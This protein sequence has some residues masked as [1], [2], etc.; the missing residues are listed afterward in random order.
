MAYDAARYG[1][2]VM[3]DAMKAHGLRY[4]SLNPGSSFRGLHDS[5]VNY[6]GNSPEII[7]CPHE[8]VA[9][10]LAHGYA[11]A[12]GEAMGVI[13]HNVVGLL[14][15][16][17]GIYYAYL[18]RTPVVIFGGT[19]PMALERRRPN[20]DWI[21]TANVQGNAVRDYTK[22]DDQPATVRSVPETIARGYRIAMSEPR[23]PV[24]ICLDAGLQE[25][26][27]TEE[28]PPVDP[29]RYQVPS[30][31]GPDPLALDRL[32]RMLVDARRPVIVPGY[33]GRDPAAFDQLVELAEL[34]G[35]GVIDTGIRLNFPN[36]HPLNVTGSDD[37]LSD[38]DLVFFLDVKDF[39]KPTQ[40]LDRLTRTITSRIPADAKIVD[41]GFNDLEISSWSHDF[42]ALHP[43]DLQVTADSAVALPMLLDRCKE[44][45]RAD[46]G[47]RPAR[48]ERKS[49][50]AGRHEA[51]WEGW[52]RQAKADRDLSPVSTSRLAEEVW[53][54]VKEHDWVL[55]AGTASGW[56]PRIWDFDRAYRH[57][58]ASLGTATQISISLGVAL[59]HKGSGKLVVDLQPDGDLMFDPGALWVAAYHKIPMLVVMFNNR[60]YYN[61]WEHQERIAR[62]RGTPVENA[63]LG[64]E[65]DGPAP[66]FANIARSFGWYGEGP[67][68]DPEQVQAAV[69]RAAEIVMSTG[70]PALVDV[71]CQHE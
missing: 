41:L 69:R 57:P 62:H 68:D 67:I 12:T 10:G 39:G 22:W 27:L 1:S 43:T 70:Q 40:V 11:K 33:A 44:L 14:H 21:H 7:E 52:R 54:V 20:I 25:D 61:D 58:G 48:E 24:Y 3:V 2:D 30:R 15:G 16:A 26:E 59:A 17:M 9:V 55:T 37:A 29:A 18:D 38:A 71:V 4:V 32:A 60:A 42:T 50:L 47:R 23:G 45:E 65:I 28:I 6:G 5:I 13:L 31:I 34:L 64:M 53:E 56:A 63:Y 51:V 35:A 36:R 49:V 66:D 8:K 19:G 46:P